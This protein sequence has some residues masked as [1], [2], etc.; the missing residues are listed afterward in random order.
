MPF[1]IIDQNFTN[2]SAPTILI[3]D[4][5]FTSRRILEQVVHGIQKNITVQAFAE[6]I[7]ALLWAK[8]NQ[9]DLVML[10]YMMNGMSGLEVM[11]QMQRMPSMEGVPIVIVT[12][13]EDKQIRY[14]ALKAGATDFITKPI[15]PYECGVRCQNMLA[16]RMQQKIIL[17]R[18][19]FLEHAISSATQ[20]I[21]DRELETLFRLA[22]AGE[23]RDEETGNHIIRMAKYSRLIAESLHLPEEKC[24]L[25]EVAAPMHDIGKIGISDLILLKADRLTPEEFE[26]MKTHA[27]IGY[28][29]LHN[30]PSKYINLGAEIALAHHEKYD[31]S[32]YPQGLKGKEICLEA[33]IVAVADV[34]DALTSQRPYKQAWSNEEAFAHLSAAKGKHFDP[35]CVEGFITRLDQIAQIQEQF[36]DIFDPQPQQVPLWSDD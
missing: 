10:D 19:Q 13:L 14:Q 6:P 25:I 9:P 5:E 15:D 3:L 36:Q 33:R 32:G 7:P 17:N 28:K 23:Y 20:R 4:D 8:T 30:S 34:Y 18:S 29:I 27:T 22:K 26:I 2:I 31:G 16:L 21:R 12:A 35:E 1:E 11:K 24:N